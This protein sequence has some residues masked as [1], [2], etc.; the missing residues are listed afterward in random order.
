[1]LDL[2]RRYNP[3]DVFSTIGHLELQHNN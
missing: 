2:K 1:M 3:D